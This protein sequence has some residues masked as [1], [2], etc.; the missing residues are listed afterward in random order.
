M[1]NIRFFFIEDSGN[2]RSY[3]FRY[4]RIF[5]LLLCKPFN[6]LVGLFDPLLMMT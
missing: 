3:L 5:K 2:A 1:Q 4:A 6:G